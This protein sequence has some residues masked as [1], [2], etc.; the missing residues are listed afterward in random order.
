MRIFK[1]NPFNRFAR[2]EK[3]TDNTLIEVVAEIEK[4]LYEAD[5]GGGLIKKRVARQ[6]G[7]KSG[8]YRTVVAYRKGK[9]VVFLH[10]F[11]KKDKANLS[12]SEEAAFRKLAKAYLS[13]SETDIEKVLHEKELEEVNYGKGKV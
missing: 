7:S 3:I 6:G 5:L 8:G 9:R 1:R 12:V 10:G 13:L 4:G 11:A 2:K